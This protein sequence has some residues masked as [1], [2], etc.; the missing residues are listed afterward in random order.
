ML[1][2][3][4]DPQIFQLTFATVFLC[5]LLLFTVF[6]RFRRFLVFVGIFE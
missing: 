1:T 5:I 4:P 2:L 6:V 3:L